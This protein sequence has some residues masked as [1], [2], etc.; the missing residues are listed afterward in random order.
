MNETL[1]QCWKALGIPRELIAERGL[2]VFA[3]AIELVIAETSADG[4]KHHLVPEAASAWSAMKTAARADAVDIH[5]VSAHRSVERQVE[6]V[7]RKLSAGQTLD[8]ILAVSA[9]PG[10]SEHHTG[11]AIDVGTADSPA[12]EPE[13]ESTPAYQWLT[14]HATRFG[15]ALSYPQDNR[16]G[17]SYEPWHWCYRETRERS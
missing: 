7:R 13:F 17:Y 1:W 12:L 10:C 3:E 6:I 16:W 4:R 14:V 15:F 11:R 8:E 5:I 2:P 9:P